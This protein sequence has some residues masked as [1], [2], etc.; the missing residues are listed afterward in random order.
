VSSSRM[1]TAAESRRSQS[2]FVCVACGHSENADLNAAKNILRI[3]QGVGALVP[4]RKTPSR[5]RRAESNVK[6]LALGRS[7]PESIE[8]IP[9]SKEPKGKA[10]Q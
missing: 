5:G 2:E 7:R 10:K 3:A 4:P 6:S 8:E 9:E 1:G